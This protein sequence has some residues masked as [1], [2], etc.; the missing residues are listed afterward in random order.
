MKEKQTKQKELN[1]ICRNYM[2]PTAILII[3]MMM[4]MMTVIVMTII[5]IIII[6]K[7]VNI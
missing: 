2:T 6:N 3:T 4:M 5:I 1:V 7:L